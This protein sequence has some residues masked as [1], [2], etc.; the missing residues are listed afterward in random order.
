MKD[1]HRKRR[2]WSKREEDSLLCGIRIVNSPF[3]MLIVSMVKEIGLKCSRIATCTFLAAP[4][5]I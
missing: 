5:A 4:Q 2:R 1:T 3:T